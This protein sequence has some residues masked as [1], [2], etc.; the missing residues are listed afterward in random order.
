MGWVTR[1]LRS[2]SAKYFSFE[3]SV[4]S[5][6]YL[7]FSSSQ[8]KSETFENTCSARSNKSPSTMPLAR[9]S[10]PGST[11]L[12]DLEIAVVRLRSGFGGR[13]ACAGFV[14]VVRRS[15]ERRVG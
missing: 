6:W 4:Q 7:L 3:N 14:D 5:V 10:R 11:R 13:S 8:Q 1:S 2:H 15:E 12:P 9:T